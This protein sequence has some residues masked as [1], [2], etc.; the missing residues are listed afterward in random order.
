MGIKDWLRSKSTK[1]EEVIVVR[2][3]RVLFCFRRSIELLHFGVVRVS[4]RQ[5]TI[6]KYFWYSV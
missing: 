6:I 4:I 5:Q 1:I 2:R 3:C